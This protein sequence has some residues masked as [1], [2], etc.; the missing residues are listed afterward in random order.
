MIQL[1][2]RHAGFLREFASKSMGEISSGI[3]SIG[4]QIVEHE[5]KIANPS[6]Y[7]KNW[8]KLDAREQVGLIKKWQKDI[9]RQKEQK[10][11]LENLKKLKEQTR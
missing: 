10:E 1:G 7:I 9:Q 6:K 5:D 3:K 8:D 11:I 4:K 2:G